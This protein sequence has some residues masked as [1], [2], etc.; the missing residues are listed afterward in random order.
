MTP[1]LL[2]VDDWAWRKG[3]SYGTILCD[4][5]QH[6]VVDLLPDRLAETFADWL[7]RHPGIEVISRDRAS[8]YA[9]G[10]RAGAPQAE[11]VADR[12]HL[13]KNLSDTLE[14]L[15]L[16]HA[17]A[18]RPKT[19]S[20]HQK[21]QD[22]KSTA[23][24]ARLTT[25]QQLRREQRQARYVE[26]HALYKQGWSLQA[27]AQ[28]VGI[29]RGTVSYFV[30]S[31]A[32]PELKT[33][34][35]HRRREAPLERYLP[36]L[37][38]RWKAGCH[39]GMQLWREIRAQGYTG[40]ASSVRPYIALLRQAPG[41]PLSLNAPLQ[42]RKTST[43]SSSQRLVTLALRLADHLTTQEQAELDRFCAAHASISPAITLT[44]AFA[45]MVR[46]RSGGK[47]DECIAQAQG[48]PWPEL[49]QFA[50]GVASDKAAVLAALHRVE[51]NG[52]VEGQIN[53]LKLIKR[54]MYGRA[55]FD[56]LRQRVLHAA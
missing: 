24:Q 48:S 19:K 42:K 1:R 3:R 9:E 44:Q 16:H 15:L 36:Y 5:E 31:Q 46:Q 34:Q 22:E 25:A 39:N 52:Q 35:Q 18:S 45:Q 4:L 28:E 14:R 38:E 37:Q 56:L 26:V 32:Y 10:A 20:G 54:Q 30:R 43:R 11:Q 21:L 13:L 12:W 40:S 27:I 23:P 29:D 6:R 33:P 47:L 8:G 53:R 2:G 7:R 41:E 50:N 49:Q 55:K 51:S 17:F